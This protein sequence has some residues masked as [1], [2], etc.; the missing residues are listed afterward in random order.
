MQQTETYKLNLM[1]GSDHFSP[2]PLNENMEKVDTVLGTLAAG[3]LHAALGTYTGTG[4][5]GSSAPNTLTFDFEPKLVIIVG[6]NRLGVFVRGS[7][8]GLVSYFYPDTYRDV[9]SVTW[10]GNTMRWY[11]LKSYGD[12][13]TYSSVFG[14]NQLNTANCTYYYYSVG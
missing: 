6:E 13:V 11:I 5:C 10:S 7:T 14:H 4:D 3:Q 1:E 2:Q 12:G 9:E 8:Q